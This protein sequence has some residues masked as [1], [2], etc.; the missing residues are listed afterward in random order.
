MAEEELS[1]IT[2]ST[3]DECLAA[4]FLCEVS[5]LDSV[6]GFWEGVD[7]DGN[8]YFRPNKEAITSIREW[9]CWGWIEDKQIIHVYIGPDASMEAIIRLCAHEIGHMQRPYHRSIKE[10]QKA[11]KYSDVAETA[12]RM[13]QRIMPK[14]LKG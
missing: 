8:D 10:E 7:G 6:G 13:A 3:I 4:F 12:Y 2:Y 14:K 5:E 9:S 11:C 1:Y